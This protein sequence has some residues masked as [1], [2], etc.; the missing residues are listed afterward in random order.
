MN[1]DLVTHKNKE[2]KTS[3][4]DF[5]LEMLETLFMSLIVLF[6]IYSTIAMPEQ[7][8]GASMEPTFHTGERILV[9][10]VTKYLSGFHRGDIVVLNPPGNDNV[11]YIKRI[12][13]LP[14]D[15]VKIF[16]CNVYI[17][18]DGKKFKLDETYLPSNTCTVEGPVIREGRSLK[19]EDNEYLVLGDNRAHSSDSR[20]FGVV[21]KDRFLG[22]V[23]F[24]FWP[25]NRLGLL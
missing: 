22:K 8:L 2:E 12:V 13:G 10:K 16:D 15:I 19:L 20:Y 3:T 14:G 4:R 24:R 7:V 17:S 25:I 11:D 1:V 23:V 5:I 18:L 9:E 21:K 6:V